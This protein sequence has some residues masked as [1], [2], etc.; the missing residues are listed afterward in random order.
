MSRCV[1]ALVV[2]GLALAPV[3]G[4]DPKPLWEIATAKVELPLHEVWWVGYSPDGNTLVAQVVHD[5]R[6]PPVE[7]IT[8]WDAATRKEKSHVDLKGGSNAT[9]VGLRVNVVTNRGTVLFA[10]GDLLEMPVTGG[11]PHS[12]RAPDKLVAQAVWHVPDSTEGVWL[13]KQPTDW[14]EQPL[15]TLAYGKRPSLASD[16]K[17]TDADKKLLTARLKPA[18]DNHEIRAAAVSADAARFA[19]GGCWSRF[20]KGEFRIDHSLSLYTITVG[21]VLKVTEVATVPSSHGAPITRVQFSPDGKTLA[22]G[23]GD[24]SVCLWDVAKAGKDWKPRATIAAGQFTMSALAFSPDGR[25][26][27]AGTFETKRA[28]LFLIDVVGGKQVASYHLDGGITSLAYSP[29][30]KTLVTGDGRGRVKGWDAGVLRN[31]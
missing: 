18:R 6:F 24:S 20:E 28:N 23:S 10:D 19:V 2:L 17:A 27:A 12:T 3:R 15:F 5:G 30:G 21:D 31:P 26:L 13:L 14:P 1:L 22:T 7:R 4:A 25:T 9:R 8:V 16:P 11:R 29:D